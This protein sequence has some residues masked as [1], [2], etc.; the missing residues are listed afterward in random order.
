[1]VLLGDCP[2]DFSIIVGDPGTF[3]PI[4]SG[5]GLRQDPEFPSMTSFHSGID[6]PAPE[7]TNIR[8]ASEGIVSKVFNSPTAGNYVVID[9]PTGHQSKYMHMSIPYVNKGESVR[10]GDII[11]AVGHTG[12]ATGNHLHFELRDAQGQAVDPTECYNNASWVSPYTPA[13]PDLPTGNTRKFPWW[14]IPVGV[15]VLALGTYIAVSATKE[16][17]RRR[18]RVAA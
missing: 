3:Y 2:F 7:F 16:K 17:R 15:G 18:R 14:I 9:H 5:F 11:G 13:H 8:A 6:I 4:G 10:M 12:R 1:M